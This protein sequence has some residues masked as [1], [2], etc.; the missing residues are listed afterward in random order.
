MIAI[1]VTLLSQLGG[2][3]SG[4]TRRQRGTHDIAP[5][6]F[7]L[8][9]TLVDAGGSRCDRP[10]RQRGRLE[11]R[12]GDAHTGSG[13]MSVHYMTL[14]LCASGGMASVYLVEP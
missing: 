1:S 5:S 11:K 10:E 12:C 6:A 9:E 13:L 4:A 14:A 2:G 3:A 8:S 7:A